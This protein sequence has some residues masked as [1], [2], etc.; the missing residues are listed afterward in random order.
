MGIVDE[1]PECREATTLRRE[2][3]DFADPNEVGDTAAENRFQL[4]EVV[5]NQMVIVA[6]NPRVGVPAVLERSQD[7]P[8]ATYVETVRYNVDVREFLLEFPAY[9]KRVIGRGIIKDPDVTRS[10]TGGCKG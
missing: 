6:E 4:F 10:E 9:I 3:S 8:V 1:L 2:N 7:V 5:E